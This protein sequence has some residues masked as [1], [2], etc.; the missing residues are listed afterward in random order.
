VFKQVVLSLLLENNGFRDLAGVHIMSWIRRLALVPNENS[1][2]TLSVPGKE[3]VMAKLIE[4]HV[5]ATFQ[6]PKPRWTPAELRGKILDFHAI[7][8]KSA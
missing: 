1:A 2:E 8:K 3:V 4:F 5:P 6:P 7:I